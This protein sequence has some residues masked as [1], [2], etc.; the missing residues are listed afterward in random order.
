MKV[1]IT[2]E[3]FDNAIDRCKKGLTNIAIA[4]CYKITIIKGKHLKQWDNAGIPLLKKTLKARGS[5]I[6]G[7]RTVIIL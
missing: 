6:S 1:A 2:H 7:E 3:N 4:T 5:I